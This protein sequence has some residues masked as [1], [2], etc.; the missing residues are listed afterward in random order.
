MKEK[1]FEKISELNEKYIKVWQEVCELESPTNNK[2]AVDA[3]GEYFK[4]L[5]RERGW[6]I[7][8]FPE[9][10]AGDVVV[11]TMNP[12]AKGVPVALSGHMDTVHAIGSFGY[13]AVRIEGDKIYGPGVTDCKGGIVAGFL[14]MDALRECGFNSRPVV[15]YLQSD[16]EGGGKYSNDRTIGRICE[17][18]QGSAAF[19]NLEGGDYKVLTLYRKGIADFYFT[20]KGIEAHSARCAVEGANAVAEAAHK[21]VEL[22][23]FKDNE[24]LTASCNVIKGGT[25][26]NTVAGECNFV[27]NVRF[28]TNAQLDFF[29]EYV[30]KLAKEVNVVGCSTSVTL[31]RV[32]PAMEPCEKNELLLQKLNQI[33]RE[34]GMSELQA[35]TATGG[36][37]AANASVSGLPAVDGLGT[38]GGEIHTVNEY[39]YLSS[40]E[41][42]A[43]RIA[44]ALCYL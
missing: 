42:Q 1:I 22:E 37:D 39:S 33:W 8:V 43:K 3:V 27:A 44:L 5:A 36:S 28:L 9:E 23:K 12:D 14:A 7:D 18:A 24:G 32:R 17:A 34:N 31:P 6:M 15:M 10:R 21:I 30:E 25:V 19:L 40:L 35:G 29:R 11:I 38:I 20:V 13:P 2:A 16:E 4:A 26:Q 41:L